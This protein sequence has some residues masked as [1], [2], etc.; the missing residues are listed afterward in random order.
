M[1]SNSKIIPQT[2]SQTE[3]ENL[4]NF[5]KVWLRNDRE[6]MVYLVCFAVTGQG[7]YWCGNHALLFEWSVFASLEWPGLLPLLCYHH[8]PCKWRV[9]AHSLSLFLS[10]LSLSLS[11]SLSVSLSLSLFLSLS[12]SP[13]LS[14][15]LSLSF[16]LS[17]SLSLFL[18]EHYDGCTV[19]N[20]KYPQTRN[21]LHANW[22]LA[23]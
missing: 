14:L 22:T 10:L 1:P 9:S 23:R 15:S 13:S 6:R 4:I 2:P 21:N 5:L 19:M 7:L 3:I 11:L 16:S 12:L 18:H 20:H 8:W 17:L